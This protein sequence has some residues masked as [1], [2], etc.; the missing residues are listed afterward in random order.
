[1]HKHKTQQQQPQKKR[2][3]T[4]TKKELSNPPSPPVPFPPLFVNPKGIL[5]PQPLKKTATGEKEKREQG[6]GE[7]AS[8]FIP[9]QSKNQ[10]KNA[11]KMRLVQKQCICEKERKKVRTCNGPRI[12]S[13][14]A[15]YVVV[16]AVV[17]SLDRFFCHVNASS[18]H[19]SFP[20]PNPPCIN[21]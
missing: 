18:H 17:L 9:M 13:R 5:N 1:M 7:E 20:R 15:L 12:P 6:E 21:R 3:V 19:P 4:P 11:Q 16:V 14:C 10:E 2:R 8:N